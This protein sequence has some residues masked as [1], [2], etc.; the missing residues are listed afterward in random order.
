MDFVERWICCGAMDDA[1]V[2]ADIGAVRRHHD[3]L[4]EEF[5]EYNHDPTQHHI[6]VRPTRVVITDNGNPEPV[7]VVTDES[8]EEPTSSDDEGEFECAWREAYLM[9]TRLVSAE[10]ALRG[11]QDTEGH[12]HNHPDFDVHSWTDAV[13][14]LLSHMSEMDGGHQCQHRRTCSRIVDLVGGTAGLPVRARHNAWRRVYHQLKGGWE[15]ECVVES[16]GDE[17]KE[18]AEPSG[19]GSGA[20]TGKRPSPASE[21]GDEPSRKASKS[22]AGGVIPADA[23]SSVFRLAQDVVEVQAHRRVKQPNPYARS[24]IMEIKNRLGC[25]APNEANKLAVRRM[26]INSM[27]RRKLRPSHI[28]ATVELVIA[29]VFVPDEHDLRSAKIL[30]SA[31]MQALRE[32]VADAGPKSV[33][34]NLVHPLRSRRV[35][36][37]PTA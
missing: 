20:G 8:D 6:T 15:A 32:E 3:E 22:D 12:S 25:P 34:Y 18:P 23:P 17:G 10:L 29:G 28:R 1:D 19:N 30:Q 36:R 26:A 13:M 16:D 21:G 37:V 5:I 11:V 33:W 4:A 9:W 31:S 7:T 14:G 2:L 35:S 27:E 24:V